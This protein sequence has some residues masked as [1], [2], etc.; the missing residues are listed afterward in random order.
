VKLIAMLLGWA[1]LALAAGKNDALTGVWRGQI[2]GLPALVMTISDEGGELSGAVL[3][4]LIRRDPGQPPRSTPGVPEP[5]FN[6]RFDGQTL[7][8]R[9]SHR[10]AHPPGSANDPPVSFQLTITGANEGRLVQE[11]SA[12]DAR[13]VVRDN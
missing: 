3:F 12:S 6:V 7:E 13:R 11:G 1:C 4:Y 9:V 5:M 2:D 10:R 8:F